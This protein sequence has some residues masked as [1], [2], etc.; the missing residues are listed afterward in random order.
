MFHEFS[1]FVLAHHRGAENTEVSIYPSMVIQQD[2]CQKLLIM[3]LHLETLTGQ[4]F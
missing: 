1:A 3:R 2:G 4:G